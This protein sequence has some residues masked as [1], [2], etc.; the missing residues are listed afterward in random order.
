MRIGQSSLVSFLAQLTSSAVGLVATLY[1]TQNL[2]SA[3]FGQ[4]T[5]VIAAATWLQVVS[6]LGVD[7]AVTQRMASSDDPGSYL[8][9]GV[10]IA[11]SAFLL[12]SV[13]LLAFRGSVRA[14]L[15]GVPVE[16][17]VFVLFGT[18]SFALVVAALSGE[19]R[20]HLAN[21]LSPASMG[22][23]SGVQIL[24]V[25][26]SGALGGLLI[27]HAAGN[28]LGVLIGLA[29]LSTGPSVPPVRVLR[30]LSGFARYS[31]LHRVGSRAFATIDVLVLG[32]FVGSSLIGYYQ[33]AWNLASVLGVF[34]TSIAQSVFPTLGR[35]EAAEDS[36]L[37][38]GAITDAT[39]YTGLLLIPGIAG[40]AVIGP[41]VM[42]IYGQG[43]SQAAALLVILCGARLAYTFA[44]QFINALNALDE[45]RL[46]YRV[47]L[48]FV[49]TNVGGNLLFIHLFGWY[50]AA[51]ATTLSAVAALVLGFRYVRARVEFEI[52]VGELSRQAASAVVM[53]VGV[54]VLQG[55]VGD[56]IGWTGL[57]V[58]VGAGTYFVTLLT[59]ST[60]FRGVV[61]RN[62]PW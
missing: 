25:V 37:I 29:L 8:S 47:N 21:L 57:L 1:I 27:G 35:A 42:A 12:V 59:W 52:P 23:R 58:A 26:T 17:L 45:P 14:Y 43:F 53:A 10:V 2:G 38:Q 61:R 22:V 32:L 6:L 49:L 4:Y 36:S 16:L 44:E 20:V 28:L 55:G 11:G 51:A 19:N 54:A 7:I 39:T 40:A 24:V 9:G 31:W 56:G 62:V 60:R 30:N 41:R 46:A 18:V 3:V 33:A 13:C 34:G 48:V 5:L 50:G 15:R